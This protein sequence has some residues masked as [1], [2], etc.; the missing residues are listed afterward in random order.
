MKL[1]FRTVVLLISSAIGMTTANA[2]EVPTHQ[3]LTIEAVNRSVLVTDPTLLTD[4]D[5][6]G[7]DAQYPMTS[8]A[9]TYPGR[10]VVSTGA[11]DEDG[12]TI[13]DTRRVFNHFYDVQYNHYAGRGMDVL[14][15]VGNPSPLWAIE[16]SGEVLDL[17]NHRPQVFS[18]RQLQQYYYLSLTS[19]SRADRIYNFGRVLESTGH[20]VHHLQDMAQPQ[21]VRNDQHLHPLPA[22]TYNPGWA[23]YEQYS[24]RKFEKPGVLTDLLNANSYPP[25]TFGTSREFWYTTGTTVARY[26]G[27]GEFTS[28][29]FIS[30]GTNFR[31]TWTSA[32]GID[33]VPTATEPLPNKYNY[34]GTSKYIETQSVTVSTMG[35]AQ[36]SGY[37]D[38]VIGKAFDEKFG[39]ITGNLRVAATSVTD[40]TAWG[41][42]YGQNSGRAN[43]FTENTAIYDDEHRVLIPRAVGFSAGLINHMFRGRL[44][45]TRSSPSTPSWTVTNLSGTLVNGSTVGQAIA[46]RIALYYDDSNGQ[47][48]PL[49]GASSQQV[50][51]AYGGSVNIGTTEPPSSTTKIIAVFMGKVGAEGD[52]NA[53]ATSGFYAVAGK[54]VSFQPLS[55]P[56][57]S[58][59]P[60]YPGFARAGWS[61]MNGDQGINSGTA[62]NPAY[63]PGLVEFGSTA[64]V[65]Q[66]EF[67]TVPV[68]NFQGWNLVIRSGSS[69][70]PIVYA[71]NGYMSS[72]KNFSFAHPGGYDPLKTKLFVKL[73]PGNPEPQGIGLPWNLVLSCPGL[74]I[75]DDQ[76]NFGFVPVALTVNTSVGFCNDGTVSFKLDGNDAG[77]VQLPRGSST[78]SPVYASTNTTMVHV[79]QHT[80]S[81]KTSISNSKP[82]CGGTVTVGFSDRAG[83]HSFSAGGAT[84]TVQ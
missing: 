43:V 72:N 48:L 1:M 22:T 57:S 27:M 16:D 42:A 61:P 29:N 44:G 59:Y 31:P 83:V 51:L 54:V 67:Q 9:G 78:T 10:T 14:G 50:S 38:F 13:D 18:V 84:I 70:G 7:I 6:P 34:D 46:G 24:W 30:H 68:P 82:G 32:N 25:P 62:L 5:M 80:A 52:P 45:L 33:I 79:G 65:I 20:V 47:R 8:T 75:T 53:D 36:R 55:I 76:R 64:G 35:G 28:N 74:Q 12:H 56:C 77:Q 19:A 71:S 60:G 40:L 69:T 26:L 17:D 73:L 37:V 3:A 21:H 23:L 81:A 4:I 41:A 63:D 58:Y 11:A 15:Y 2:Y 39:A 66:G 49:P